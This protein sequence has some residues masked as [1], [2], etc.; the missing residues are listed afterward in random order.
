MGSDVAVITK[1]HPVRS[2]SNAAQGGINAA[3]GGEGSDDTWEVHA[4]DTVKGSDWLGDQAA[5]EVMAREAPQDIYELEHMG[6]V[7]ARDEYGRLATRAFGGATNQRTFF[8][9]DITGQAILHVMHEQLLKSGMRVYEEWFVLSLIKEE[10]ACVGVVAMDII[11]GDV[12]VI[13]ARS[14][15]LATGGIG[16]AYEPS[17]NGLICTGDGMALA[18]RIGAPLMDM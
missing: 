7:F 1:V 15:I 6:V 4:Y 17:T 2:H 14:I 10:G 13:R 12:E 11:S 3:M 5:I 18:Y 16:R 8:V 9:A